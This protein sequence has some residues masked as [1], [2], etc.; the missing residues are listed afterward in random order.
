MGIWGMT[1][2]VRHEEGTT[3]DTQTLIWI[4]V[5]VVIVSVIILIVYT[6]TSRQRQQ[7]E[8]AD[9]R[10]QADQAR[11][12]GQDE[13]LRAR[14]QT[15]EAAEQEAAAYRARLDAERLE[16]AAQDRAAEAEQAHQ[17]A[18]EH[19]DEASALD[20]G[21]TS[22]WEDRGGADLGDEPRERL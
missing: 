1:P 14:Q 5:A 8:L 4:A 12:L 17:Q 21:R 10:E 6:A 19:F 7:R 11:L 20:P 3:M 15:A 13:G 18:Q 9:R 22:P 16:R 2:I